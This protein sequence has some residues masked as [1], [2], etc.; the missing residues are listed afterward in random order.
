MNYRD[1]PEDATAFVNEFA[2]TYPSLIDPSAE[3]GASFGVVGVPTT[4]L[5]RGGRL[6]HFF[7]GTVTEERLAELIERELRAAERGG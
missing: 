1:T 6:V 5:A 3:I 7:Q 4:F 2:V